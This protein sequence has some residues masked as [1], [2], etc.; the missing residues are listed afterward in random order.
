[1]HPQADRAFEL[2]RTIALPR[3]DSPSLH[4][5]PASG[6]ASGFLPASALSLHEAL[7]PPEA[8]DARC[9]QPTSATRTNDDYPFAVRSRLSR[10]TF[11]VRDAPQQ[12]V[13]VTLHGR[14]N[15]RFHDARTASAS[16][17]SERVVLVPLPRGFRSRAWACSTRGAR[18]DET[19]D[20]SVANPSSSSRSRHFRACSRFLPLA[21]MCSDECVRVGRVRN[22][23]RP[24]SSPAR[25]DRQL[26]MI[27]GAFRR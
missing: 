8:E 4:P 12:S 15:E 16:N 21:L 18:W 23:P 25:E 24:S 26:E 27:R 3:T 2:L 9:V 6:S 1:L 17:T 10:T 7:R 19:S 22:P 20:T 13:A 5:C 11:A 14:G